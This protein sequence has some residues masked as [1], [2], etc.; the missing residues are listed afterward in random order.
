MN[1]A[2]IRKPMACF[3]IRYLKSHLIFPQYDHWWFPIALIP[4][5]SLEDI[6]I[7]LGSAIHTG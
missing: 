3:L 6:I 2:N 4:L 1:V 5:D 7:V